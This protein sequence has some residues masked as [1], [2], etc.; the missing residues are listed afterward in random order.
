M[1]HDFEIA[2]T[3]EEQIIDIF[4]NI[5]LEPDLTMLNK[6][7]SHKA[8]LIEHFHRL[9][10]S[11]VRLYTAYMDSKTQ[12]AELQREIIDVGYMPPMPE[13]GVSTGWI[14]IPRRKTQFY[15]TLCKMKNLG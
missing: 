6:V 4:D 7:W 15:E 14:S 3:F 10:T 9:D 12:F 11:L 2:W 1:S 5:P 8:S 13:I